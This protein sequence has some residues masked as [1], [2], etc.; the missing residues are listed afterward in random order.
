M[1]TLNPPNITVVITTKNRG[2]TLCNALES[3]FANEYKE[4]RVIIVDQ[5]TDEI[6]KNSIQKYINNHNVTYIKSDEVGYSRGKNIGISKS[7]TEMI[8]IT[9]D[10]CI[11]PKNWVKC[12]VEA[13]REDDKI[14]IIFGNVLPGQ[15]D[16]NLG[17]IPSYIREKSYIAHSINVKH[18][19]EG[20]SACMGLKKSMWIKLNGFDKML[21]VGAHFRSAEET[22]L[23]IKALLNSYKVYET[24]KVF[25]THHGFRNW[26]ESSKLINSYWYGTG[27]MFA[28]HLKCG[29]FSILYNLIHLA[30]RWGFGK[31]RV[32]AVL[33]KKQYRLL[34]L[35]SFSK[36]FIEGFLTP[37]DKEKEL[38][39]E[40]N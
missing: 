25:V 19:V 14:G 5:S 22:D 23:T 21:G 20:I 36:G 27:A 38:F 32:I 2:D 11:V 31:S 18:N 35:N 7:N 24:P 15:Y 34:R 10:D 4:F 28:K 37:V 39:I 29:H 13:F 6:T 30:F 1:N 40:K 16:D 17:F 8:A 26:E 9:D 12:M 3:I 33:G